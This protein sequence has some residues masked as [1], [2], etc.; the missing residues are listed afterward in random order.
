MVGGR[1][2]ATTRRAGASLVIHGDRCDDARIGLGGRGSVRAVTTASR[3]TLFDRHAGLGAKIGPFAGWE[4]PLS[5]GS[6]RDE[7]MAVRTHAGLF[8]VSHMGQLELRGAGTGDYLLRALTNDV[9]RLSPG[10]GQYTLML[11]DDG[12]VIDDLIAYR[13]AD[14][15]LL[16]VNAS[17]IAACRERLQNRLP[18]GVELVDRSPETAML[19]LQGPAWADVV[20]PLL[21]D[22]GVLRAAYFEVVEG[23]VAGVDALLARTGYTGEPGIEIMCAA[24]RAP[25]VWDALVGGAT[26]AVPAGLVAR[27]TLRVEMGYPLYGQELNRTRTPIE[28]GLRWACDLEGARFAGADTCVAQ[29]QSGTPE[30]LVA[31]ALTEQGIPR[32]GQDV[33][34]GDRRVG[35]VTSGTLSP[36]L[37]H[38]IGMAYVAHDLA[39]PGADIEIDVR[40]KRKTAR[41]AKRPLVDTSPNRTK[42]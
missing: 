4:M 7:H 16:V 22:D 8:D 26:A 32:P 38:G 36:V 39:R 13:L 6:P 10:Q 27:D 2:R 17:N 9:S 5:Y 34:H 30:R 25:A 15:H 29:A 31:F 37:E 18:D 33:I 11:E 41:T 28:A 21:E 23:R 24:E 35:T 20:T 1:P 42:G 3:T 12:G 40:G 14:R 19:A